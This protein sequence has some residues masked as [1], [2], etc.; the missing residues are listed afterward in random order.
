VVVHVDAP[1]L[2]DSGVRG[3]TGEVAEGACTLETG[4]ALDPE[5]ARRLACDASVVRILE[6][7]GRPLSV[8]R[9]TRSVPPALRRALRSRDRTCRFPG[10]CQRRFLHA[11]HIDHW[12]HGGRTELANLIHLCGFHHRLVHEGG[13]TIQR[14]GAGGLEFRRPDGQPLAV[15]SRP[16][17]DQHELGRLHRRAGLRLDDQTCVPRTSYER[18]QLAWVVDGLADVDPRLRE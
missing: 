2:G 17:G 13:Y 7:D 3:A 5:T 8:G 18:F 9:K 6:H 16:R 10:C 14:R 1:V 11:H 12:A 4:P 15:T